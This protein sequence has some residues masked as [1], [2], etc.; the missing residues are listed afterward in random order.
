MSMD[1]DALRHEIVELLPRLRRYAYALTGARADAD[2]LLQTTVERLLL[3]GVPD[4]AH[5]SKWAF[6]VC[7]NIW[8]DEIRARNV[9]STAAASGKASSEE[10]VDGERVIMD[11]LAFVEVNKAMGNLPDEQ[12]AALS[13]VA[14][15]GLSYAEAAETLGA[16]I[17]TIMSRIARA[18]KTLTEILKADFF[19][20]DDDEISIGE[21]T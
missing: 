5:M 8:I 11:K 9:R 6:R 18:R 7:K 10:R 12:R 17:G 16:P 14:L 13:L 2:D 21:K 15:E 1:A 19:V 3:R 4:D 20:P